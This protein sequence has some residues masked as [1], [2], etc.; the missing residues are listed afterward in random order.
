MKRFLLLCIIFGYFLP[1]QATVIIPIKN[2]SASSSNLLSFPVPIQA[3]AFDRANG[4]FFVG[5]APGGG[6]LALSAATISFG[7]NS[8]F[9]GIAL[10]VPFNQNRGIEFLTLATFTGDNNPILVAVLENPSGLQSAQA[11]AISNST[12]TKTSDE[13]SRIN[14]ASGAVNIDGLPTSGIVGLAASQF[15]AFPAVK[16]CGGN[17]GSDCNGGIASIAINK[18][19]YSVT[20]VPAE[21][22]D[23]GIKAA[24]FDPTIPQVLINNSPTIVPNTVDLY[25]DDQLQRLYIG[26]QLTTAGTSAVGT[27]CHVGTGICNTAP[28]SCPTGFKP[29]YAAQACVTCPS[30]GIY[31]SFG[32][33]CQLCPT[34]QLFNPNAFQCQTVT[35]SPGF[36]FNTDPAVLACA[37][38]FTGWTSD[39][40]TCFTCQN[41]GIFNPHFGCIAC[42]SGTTFNPTAGICTTGPITCPSGQVMNPNGFCVTPPDC[43]PGFTADL[44]NV[45]CVPDIPDPFPPDPQPIPPLL[46]NMKGPISITAMPPLRSINTRA[47]AS[48][49]RS[50]VTASVDSSGIISF[51]DIAP[52]SAFALNNLDNMVGVFSNTPQSLAINKVRVLHASTGPSYL[53]INGGNGTINGL[54]GAIF[55]L[56]LVDLGDPTNPTQGT[57]A[58]KN[59]ALDANFKFVTPATT[60]AG[61]PLDTD[62]AV[63]VGTGSLA[64]PF[65]GLIS[66]I[67]VIGDTVYVSIDNDPASTTEGGILYS[68]ALFDETGKIIRWTPWTKKVFPP[69]NTESQTNTSAVT[70]FSVDAYTNKTWVVDDERITVVQNSWSDAK[71]TPSKP[72][73]SLIGQ[74]NAAITGTSSAVLDLDQSTRGFLANQSRYALFAGD[75]NGAVNIIFTRISQSF[76]LSLSLSLSPWRDI[77]R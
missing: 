28:L 2:P 35:C 8:I 54:G 67:D 27:T 51:A 9:N 66:D 50:I 34:G 6:N 4:T 75:V 76:S 19:T 10:D 24:L 43:P 63:I 5:L 47:L 36:F 13:L 64:L 7:D 74:L 14:D 41:G 31:D 62:P 55:A 69:F 30:G 60:P 17:F 72:N 26:I 52:D 77:Y 12:G 37:S 57:V 20:Q 71:S 46:N 70:F 15:F 58:D 11:I 21:S 3:K 38:C 23:G 32:S 40:I 18:T 53:I 1:V 56:P 59:S 39:G 49:G 48:G 22:G 42:P 29:D 61:M 33:M 44:V 65:T 45:T 73:S 16:P 25:W 68:Q